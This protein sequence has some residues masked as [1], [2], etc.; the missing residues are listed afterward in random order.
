MLLP[1]GSVN[2]TSKQNKWFTPT[3]ENINLCKSQILN[4]IHSTPVAADPLKIDLLSIFD[5]IVTDESI[6]YTNEL[7]VNTISLL[8]EETLDGSQPASKLIDQDPV[9]ATTHNAIGTSNT[10]P[11]QIE[12]EPERTTVPP[13]DPESIKLLSP[14]PTST[15]VTTPK[16]TMLLLSTIIISNIID[17]LMIPEKFFEDKLHIDFSVDDEINS[18]FQNTSSDKNKKPVNKVVSGLKTAATNV[19]KVL[20]SK[21]G[22]KKG[23]NNTPPKGVVSYLGAAKNGINNNNARHINDKTFNSHP[24]SSIA[25]KVNKDKDKTSLFSTIASDS[26][27][28][29]T[30]TKKYDKVLKNDGP[31]LLAA[32]PN[33]KFSEND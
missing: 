18:S 10:F 19:K 33:K 24:N 4:P 21:K 11:K 8:N 6:N 30:K 3:K 25:V 22:D 14:R 5:N 23:K 17:N 27:W 31:L 28:D 32:N 15:D 29:D 26:D 1:D 7:S 16:S 2:W 12:Q 9:G 20:E 13:P